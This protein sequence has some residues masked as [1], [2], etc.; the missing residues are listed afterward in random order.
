MIEQRLFDAY[1]AV[2][3]DDGARERMLDNILARSSAPRRDG[4]R[5]G[6]GK[7][8]VM[9]L[10]AAAA[11][12]LGAVSVYAAGVFSLGDLFVRRESVRIG[13]DRSDTAYDLIY[14]SGY[15]DTP[16]YR[17]A[18]E[19][20][21]FEEAYDPDGAIL[22]SVGNDLT[23]T[24]ERG[25]IYGCYTPEMAEELERIAGKYGLRLLSGCEI[26]DSLDGLCARAGT[27]DILKPGD[28]MNARHTE[29]GYSYSDGTFAFDGTITL[30]AG[31]WQYPIEY[32]FIR[33]RRGTM[34][35]NV[36]NVEE[37]DAYDEWE[38]T[39]ENGVSLLLALGPQKAL[40][41][42]ERESS[43]VTVN[44]LDAYAGDVA[45]GEVHMS[46]GDLE[47]LAEC[48]DFSAIP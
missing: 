33:S 42:A 43:F 11:L 40:I 22:Q 39:T 3:P 13:G 44:I 24:D 12:L 45:L 17:A 34:S 5:A 21:A 9:I 19:W 25:L 15:A 30:P 36:L 46:R 10:A 16:E 38:Y 37:L 18:M 8:T 2:R 27:G 6:P 7:R 28:A 31:G 35:L 1:D 47:A 29:A 4:R 26:S 20:F 48:F 14:L 23:G 41:A 32:Q